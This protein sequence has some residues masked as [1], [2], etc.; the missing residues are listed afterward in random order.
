M[1][2]VNVNELDKQIITLEVNIKSMLAALRL[3]YRQASI[4][5][6]LAI[7]FIVEDFGTVICAIRPGDHDMIK[8]IMIRNYKD[9]RDVYIATDDSFNGMKDEVLWELMRSGYMTF[10]RNNYTRQ[11]NNIILNE[12]GNKIIN[13]RLKIWGDRP[14][15][16]WLVEENNMAKRESSTYV[17]SKN[18]AF[19]DYMPSEGG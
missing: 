7:C 19:F 4:L 17:L 1:K 2:N 12:L 14:R 13:K 3:N 18:P 11:F 15:Y 8:D 10:I 5:N 6:N 16:K 9:W